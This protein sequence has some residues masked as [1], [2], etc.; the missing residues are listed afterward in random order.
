MQKQ[1][2]HATV[3]IIIGINSY[4]ITDYICELMYKS[5]AK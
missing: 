3:N 1:Y 5:Q 2:M 4:F